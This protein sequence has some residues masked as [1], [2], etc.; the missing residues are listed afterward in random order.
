[1]KFVRNI[2][3]IKEE[4]F[5]AI[6]NDEVVETKPKADSIG[7]L[8]TAPQDIT[9]SAPTLE[10][11][12]KIPEFE[13]RA[14]LNLDVVCEPE[15]TEGELVEEAFIA[16]LATED[17]ILSDEERAVGEAEAS[18]GDAPEEV[19]KGESWEKFVDHVI[20]PTLLTCLDRAR[21]FISTV[22]ATDLK[23]NNPDAK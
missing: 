1:M 6:V 18:V 3:N 2:V 15:S 12:Y 16:P 10:E 5:S 13:P 19:E 7:V 4:A 17:T 8:V 9:D 14:K 11:K 21:D 20:V 23:K 22:L